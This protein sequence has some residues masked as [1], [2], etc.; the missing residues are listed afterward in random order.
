MGTEISGGRKT[1]QGTPR[2][3]ARARDDQDP[4]PKP[5]KQREGDEEGTKP[6]GQGEQGKDNQQPPALDTARTQAVERAA[7]EP[8]PRPKDDAEKTEAEGNNDRATESAPPAQ[9]TK[10]EAPGATNPATRRK[11]TTEQ[12]SKEREPE[13]PTAEKP[14]TNARTHIKYNCSQ[15]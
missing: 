12:G 4:E 9:P 7:K 8:R 5:P 1:R 11:A 3:T 14:E 13:K 15:L 6:G 10:T 2:P